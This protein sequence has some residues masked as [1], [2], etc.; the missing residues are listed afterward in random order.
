MTEYKIKDLK[1]GMKDIDI[2]VEIDF[3]GEKKAT[4]GF[5]NDNLIPAI[6]KDETGE[7][8]FTFWNDDIKKAKAGKKVKIEGGYVTEYNGQLQLRNLKEKKVIFL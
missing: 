8:Q 6:V 2:T 4:S 3:T 1:R 7:I 5:D